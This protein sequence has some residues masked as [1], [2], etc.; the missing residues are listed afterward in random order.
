MEDLDKNYADTKKIFD[1]R[2]YKY[3]LLIS[4]WLTVHLE[5]LTYA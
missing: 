3:E 2:T 4:F 1:N 5:K